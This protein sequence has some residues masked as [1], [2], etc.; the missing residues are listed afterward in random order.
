MNIF[1]CFQAPK[2]GL[3]EGHVSK[4]H[5]GRLSKQLNS[6]SFSSDTLKVIGELK[7]A[8]GVVELEGRKGSAGKLQTLNKLLARA[9]NLRKKQEYIE[10]YKS[11]SHG[12]QQARAD[13]NTEVAAQK[14]DD[15]RYGC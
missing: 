10:G 7:C 1:K 3:N 9:D 6:V 4:E 2:G 15:I 12:Q 8:K 11:P 14:R 5:V 13:R